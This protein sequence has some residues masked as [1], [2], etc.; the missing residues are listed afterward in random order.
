MKCGIFDDARKKIE[1]TSGSR[2]VKTYLKPFYCL[3]TIALLEDNV[4]EAEEYLHKE[5]HEALK[6]N[7]LR[8]HNDKCLAALLLCDVKSPKS[9]S[10]RLIYPSRMAPQDALRKLKKAF[11]TRD[12]EESPYH[13]LVNEE[14][15]D[16]F[17]LHSDGRAVRHN[18][19]GQ[20]IV[21]A[22]V[23]SRFTVGIFESEAG[24]QISA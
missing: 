4:T 3:G 17:S 23:A 7:S 22:K 16:V 15:F 14:I 18:S 19:S 24:K 8:N 13:L 20:Y 11:K 12:L 2:Y 21:A 1:S 10:T 6:F 5:L 9:Q